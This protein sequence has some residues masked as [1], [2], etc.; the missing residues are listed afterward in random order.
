[1]IAVYELIGDG[2]VLYIG[3]TANPTK[4]GYAHRALKPIDYWPQIRIVRWFKTRAAALKLEASMI[5]R[6]K[7]PLNMQHTGRRRVKRE[8]AR[9]ARKI[10]FSHPELFT[11]ELVALLPPGWSY[12]TALR[13]FGPRPLEYSDRL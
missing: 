5:R 9:Q 2:Q 6:K 1:M 4:R 3:A 8:N 7:P 11:R 13:E 12:W 10:W